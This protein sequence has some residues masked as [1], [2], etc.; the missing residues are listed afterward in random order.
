[1]GRKRI[2]CTF[3]NKR[4]TEATDNEGLG[5][6]S[7]LHALELSWEP[8]Q[9]AFVFNF[10]GD[11]VAPFIG[12]PFKWSIMSMRLFDSLG[13]LAPVVIVAKIFLLPLW[14]TNLDRY[15]PLPP[16]LQNQWE[17]IC[18]E[19]RA[20]ATFSIPRWLGTFRSS[21][22]KIYGLLLGIFSRRLRSRSKGRFILSRH[23]PDS[24]N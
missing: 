20:G 8:N 1:M 15:T 24:E 6:E 4:C 12:A 14:T 19:F 16:E 7:Y 9:D 3:N 21:M 10:C 2:S 22:V 18:Q 23:P 11:S 5:D 13:W 17:T